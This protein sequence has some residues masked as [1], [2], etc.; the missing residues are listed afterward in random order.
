MSVPYS[1]DLHAHYDA[2]VP[3]SI[4]TVSDRVSQWND[5]SPNGR[6]LTQSTAN[7]RPLLLAEEL[8]GKNVVYYDGLPGNQRSSMTCIDGSIDTDWDDA[9]VFG[10]IKSREDVTQTLQ[11]N[12]FFIKIDNS[13]QSHYGYLDGNY[14][15]WYDSFGGSSRPLLSL[16]SLDYQWHVCSMRRDGNVIYPGI[17]G[18]EGSGSGSTKTWRSPIEI[19]QNIS[20]FPW[21]GYIAE[22]VL[23]NRSLI[24]GEFDEVY[25]YL[26]NK[27]LVQSTG[28]TYDP[29]TGQLV[30]PLGGYE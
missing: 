3:A 26:H 1:D 19:G 17:N 22:V 23:Y 18:T 25:S 24:Q 14:S 29:L 13:I 5:L 27:W 10:V 7:N 16:N 30:N 9:T 8:D 6:H 12:G 2:S 15:Q 20:S 4:T 21:Q 11:R 28:A